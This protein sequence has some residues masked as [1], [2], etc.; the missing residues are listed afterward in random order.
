[1][2]TRVELHIAV[3]AGCWQAELSLNGNRKLLEGKLDSTPER[4]TL[5]AMLEGLRALTR[6][7]RHAQG[8]LATCA[9]APVRRVAIPTTTSIAGTR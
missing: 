4:L 1:M 7:L 8:R 6:P 2:L 5:I 3:S 9:C